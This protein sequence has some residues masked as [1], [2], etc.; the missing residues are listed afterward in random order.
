MSAPE[1]LACNKAF[2]GEQRRYR[3]HADSTAAPARWRR[4][5]AHGPAVGG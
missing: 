1:L 4:P 3:H 5:A 2:G